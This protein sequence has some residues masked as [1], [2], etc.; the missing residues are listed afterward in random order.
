MNMESFN[1]ARKAI[2]DRKAKKLAD[3]ETE[4]KRNYEA[5]RTRANIALQAVLSCFGISV[6]LSDFDE[7]GVVLLPFNG[8]EIPV[9]FVESGFS[10]DG[11]VRFDCE[12]DGANERRFIQCNL[13]IG[14]C[15]RLFVYYMTDE[16]QFEQAIEEFSI[17]LQDAYN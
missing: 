14:D 8:Y 7:N 1:Q 16:D 6:E 11:A 9:S 3:A 10:N 15:R 5:S 2:S 17:A 12:H 13:L 4:R